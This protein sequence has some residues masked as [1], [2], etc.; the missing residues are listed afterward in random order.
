VNNIKLLTKGFLPET[1]NVMEQLFSLINDYVNQTRSLK[2]EDGMKNF[3][4]NLFVYFNNRPFNTGR[5]RGLSPLERA[6]ILN[7]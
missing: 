5:M 4:S 3:F 1:N 6:D 2:T 7:N